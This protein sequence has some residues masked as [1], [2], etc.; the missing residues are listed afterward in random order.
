M[1]ISKLERRQAA[2]AALTLVGLV[3][4]G[5]GPRSLVEGSP[6]FSLALVLLLIFYVGLLIDQA[7]RDRRR[8]AGGDQRFRRAIAESANGIALVGLDGRILE[9]NKAFA[10]ML[11]YSVSELQALA[12]FDITHPDDLAIGFES[13]RKAM[14]GEADCF[15][16]EKR[17]VRKDG[18]AIWTRLAGSVI[19][20]EATGEPSYIVSQIEDIDAQR[21]SDTALREAESRWSFALESAGQ[22]VWDFDRRRGRTYYSPLWKRILGYGPDELTDDPDLYLRLIH[23]EDRERVLAAEKEHEE[24]RTQFFEAEFR[25]R[26]KDGRWIWIRDRGNVLER[27]KNGVAMRAIGT[28]TDISRQKEAEERIIAAAEALSEE[29]ERLRITLHSIAD[30]VICTDAS[31]CVSFMN[32]AAEALTGVDIVAAYGEPLETVFCPFDEETGERLVTTMAPDGAPRW[33]GHNGRAVLV[34]PDKTR[35]SI[36]EMVSPILTAKEDFAGS[37]IVFQDVTDARALQ[38]EL[39]YAAAHD[40]LTGL[41]NRSGFLR[42]LEEVVATVAEEDAEHALLFIDLDRFKAVN[43]NAGHLAGDALLKK[44]AGAIKKRVRSND[45]VAR[46][47][48]DEFAVLLRSCTLDAARNVAELLVVAIRELDFAWEGCP[49]AVGAS[50]GVAPITPHSCERDAIIAMADDACYASKAAG[51]GR[52]SVSGE[53]VLSFAAQVVKPASLFAR[54]AASIE[55]GPAETVMQ[56]PA[57]NSHVRH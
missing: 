6:P 23:P 32:P 48:G 47:G 33:S 11:G 40:S 7:L 20:D 25:M 41:A 16:F 9:A 26:H 21:T 28:Q 2:A 24:G 19:R 44:V 1:S 10:R 3:A 49:H 50:I 31:N 18:V 29:K 46:F 39:A 36:R 22:G 8:I 42:A 30:A 35:R 34:R 37:V 5:L 54:S 12:L 4:I 13:I 45:V 17:Y 52:V 38:R 27:D 56:P 51:R 55:Q 57:P 14:A 53:N 15:R 43:D